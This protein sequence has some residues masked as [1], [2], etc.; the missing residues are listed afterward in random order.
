M[1]KNKR[2]TFIIRGLCI[3]FG[4][5]TVEAIKFFFIIMIEVQVMDNTGNKLTGNRGSQ[6]RFSALQIFGMS[7][8]RI[9][10]GV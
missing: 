6:I 5:Q 4:S 8:V 9:I 10:F 2:S 7:T 3:V 1:K